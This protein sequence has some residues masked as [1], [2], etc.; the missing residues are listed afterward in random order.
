MRSRSFLKLQ[1][2]PP[3]TRYNDISSTFIDSFYEIYSVFSLDVI[4]IVLVING[5]DW[6]EC[7]A[8]SETRTYTVLF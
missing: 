6:H 1:R 7:L 4:S 2:L 3:I 8:T 5:H